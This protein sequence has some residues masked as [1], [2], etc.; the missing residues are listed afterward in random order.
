MRQIELASR[1][2][3]GFVEAGALVV[4]QD[5]RQEMGVEEPDGL[6]VVLGYLFDIL[7]VFEESASAVLLLVN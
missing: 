7:F 5:V 3:Q 2:K 6:A 1:V 4:S